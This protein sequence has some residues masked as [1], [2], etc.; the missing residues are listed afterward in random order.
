[1]LSSPRLLVVGLLSETRLNG[2]YCAGIRFLTL[3]QWESSQITQLKPSQQV[4]ELVERYLCYSKV[5]TIY[6]YRKC[7]SVCD[8]MNNAHARAAVVVVAA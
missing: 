8:P 6:W 5:K 1:M 2:T 7:N 4:V 3:L